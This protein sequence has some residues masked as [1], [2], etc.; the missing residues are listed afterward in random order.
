MCYITPSKLNRLRVI[1]MRHNDLGYVR[2]IRV[3]WY[4]KFKKG[5]E[6]RGI[7][8]DLTINDLADLYE[9]QGGICALT[10]ERVF[11]PGSGYH[12]DYDASID[13]INSAFGYIPNNIQ[14]TSKYSNMMKASYSQ[15]KFIEVCNKV[16]THTLN[17]KREV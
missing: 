1:S 12:P 14:I 7:T 17:Q 6:R 16:A 11:M 8:W 10:G 13:R 9:K 2:S 4:S 5:A 15:E 3:S